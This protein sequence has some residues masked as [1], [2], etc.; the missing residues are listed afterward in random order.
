MSD[1]TIT[2]I[3]IFV[4]AILMFIFPLMAMSD[5]TDDMSQLSVQ[6]ATTEFVDNV[7]T[8]G[9]LSLNNYQKY[10]DS[11][12]ATGNNYEVEME[13]Q[14]LDENPGKKTTQTQ[15]TKIGENVYYSQY[16]SQIMDELNKNSKGTYTLKEGDF[17][18]ASAK[19]T[20][21]T[22]S[23]Q[24]KSAFYKVTGNDTYSISAKHGGIVTVTGTK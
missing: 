5:R 21:A 10:V 8:T 4:A 11:I 15:S 14:I 13:A 3:A 23:Q 17:F 1:S 22:I 6:T 9:V 18:S 2:I 20:N 7:R 16:T 19:N 12:S 24:L